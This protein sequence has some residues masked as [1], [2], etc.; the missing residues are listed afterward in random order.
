MQKETQW[1]WWVISLPR[2]KDRSANS[3]NIHK[4]TRALK[5]KRKETVKTIKTVKSIQYKQCSK[6]YNWY[7]T[8]ELNQSFCRT[9]LSTDINKGY[10]NYK[11]LNKKYIK[12]LM[13]KIT[14]YKVI[15]IRR[16]STR[17]LKPNLVKF[18]EGPWV[19]SNS[20]CLIIVVIFKLKATFGV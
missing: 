5:K 6:N 12:T 10:I 11:N 2:C 14:L 3:E 9:N 19:F 15:I 17:Y 8:M 20:C 4:H 16:C 13:D 1:N 18:I 7:M